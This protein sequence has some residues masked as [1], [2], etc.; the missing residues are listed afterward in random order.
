MK[1]LGVPDSFVP[2]ATQAEQRRDLGLDEDG[3]MASF[4]EHLALKGA[5]VSL[6]T[7]SA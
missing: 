2:H 4:R 1:R 7:R 6:A 3:L 5:L